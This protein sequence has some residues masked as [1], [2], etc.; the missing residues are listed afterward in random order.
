MTYPE[1]TVAALITQHTV[2][3]QF[4]NQEEKNKP[5]V[6]RYHHVWTP[7]IRILTADGEDLYHWN[8]YLPPF[9]YAP[10][11]LAGVAH[12]KLRLRDYDGAVQ[13]YEE[14]VKRYPTSIVAP[15]ALYF[16]AVARYRKSGDS[17]DLLKGWHRL[18]TRFPASPWTAK[19]DFH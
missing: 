12:A 3:L 9:E 11:L 17:S 2:P 6:D 15:E 1:T 7:D 8:G 4:N 19:Q 5:V 13:L 16:L 10:Q 14:V 18:E